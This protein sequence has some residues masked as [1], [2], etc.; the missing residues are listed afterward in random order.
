MSCKNC[1]CKEDLSVLN[2]KY[3]GNSLTCISIEEG[4]NLQAIFS[5]IN[6]VICTLK[7][8]S[9]T[10]VN[11][12]N[13]GTGK[14]AY[15]GKDVDGINEFRTF[16]QGT[17][18]SVTEQANEL[19]I[20]AVYQTTQ[21]SFDA[22]T[23]II[24]AT[25]PD[26]TQRTAVLSFNETLT[27]I[28]QDEGAGTITYIDEDGNPT[29]LNVAQ[30]ITETLTTLEKESGDLVYTDENGDEN[31]V[32]LPKNT[33]DLT[34]DGDDTVNP[35]VSQGDNISTLTNDSGFITG[36]TETDPVFIAHPSFAITAQN[37][38]D[39]EAKVSNAT[40][41]GDVTGSV[42]LTI[43]DDAVTNVKLADM[44]INTIKG[45]DVGGDPKD[46]TAGQTRA[47]LGLD[48]GNPSVD[49]QVLQGDTLGNYTWTT[50]AGAT[51]DL[52]PTDSST[53]GVESNGVFDALATKANLALSNIFTSTNE[54]QAAVT[55]N[56]SIGLAYSLTT[57]NSLSSAGGG[58]WFDA[59]RG[60]N[61]GQGT[62]A[63]IIKFVNSNT[64]KRTYNWPNKDGTVALLD[65][66]SVGSGANLSYTSSPT[67]GIVNSDTGS[68]ATLPLGTTIN[69]GLISPA[70]TTKL[71]NVTVTQPV[72]LDT[73]E[74]NVATN[75]TKVS[76]ATHTGEVT[77]ATTLTI[78]SSAVTTAKIANNAVTNAKI[79]DNTIVSSTKLTNSGVSAGTYNSV[80]VN[81]KGIVTSGSNNPL[82]DAN[83][84][85]GIDSSQFLRS[86]VADTANGA[87][88]F[89]SGGATPIRL[90]GSS[91]GD[92]NTNYIPFYENNGT[93]RQGYI[94]LPSPSHSDFTIYSD[95][96]TQS[97]KLEDTGGLTYTGDIF[98]NANQ[99]VLQNLSV[100]G[101][102]L[103][104]SNGN[105]V[106]IPSGVE[107]TTG[108]KTVTCTHS[109][110][111]FTN[112]T[113]NA[114][115]EWVKT[116]KVVFFSVQ[117]TVNRVGFSSGGSFISGSIV[118]TSLP[119]LPTTKDCAV[120]ASNVEA[121][122]IIVAFTS[123]VNESADSIQT[124]F[125]YAGSAGTTY[126]AA[127]PTIT[128]SGTYITS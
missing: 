36:Y 54:F 62:G 48:F 41:T 78:T 27:S 35:F 18:I 24:S 112:T 60:F 32:T 3:D 80:T 114:Q 1:G 74:S 69:A 19:V 98:A 33:S 39:W 91:T 124:S 110:S 108:S 79:A 63:D 6:D 81:N 66:I 97:L 14:K 25:F 107:Q 106:A 43:S 71:S 21:L 75:N 38:T 40:H 100:V 85:D 28:S 20:S 4:D 96:S 119:F 49:G 89:A 17:G 116:G 8:A 123:M 10:G 76:N 22:N 67:N 118:V 61:I 52:V 64:V 128:I 90:N 127:T 50:I 109:G 73:M 105:T 92:S 15:K 53:N 93:V 126:G 56:N 5:N 2:I 26:G 46:L 34:N 68:N 59:D 83:T 72:N 122:G 31:T 70:N 51:L 29:V 45:T 82:T 11:I 44:A 30:D 103:T 120:T 84:L 12:K 104:I 101:T 113:T 47:V 77:G 117:I 115:M 58:T 125:T 7:E 16:L 57:N 42:A 86:D 23:N 95:V 102:N 37:I 121:G 94:G 65:D 88:T 55:I 87:I 99:N 111:L 13:I 9:A